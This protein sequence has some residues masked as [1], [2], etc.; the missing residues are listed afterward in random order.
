MIGDKHFCNLTCH[1]RPV[2]AGT[3]Q[4]AKGKFISALIPV[5]TPA[6]LLPAA[7]RAPSPVFD[8]VLVVPMSMAGLLGH[9]RIPLGYTNP[10]IRWAWTHTHTHTHK[11]RIQTSWLNKFRS[12]TFEFWASA[13]KVS[14]L[15]DSSR[16]VRD[17]LFCSNVYYSSL[18]TMTTS[19]G[20]WKTPETR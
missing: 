11:Q 12:I 3:T 19:T 1:N 17:S 8:P 20:N 10:V 7:C 5:Q 6:Y 9:S 15:Q 4:P 2:Q 18:S 14:S 13:T 16:L